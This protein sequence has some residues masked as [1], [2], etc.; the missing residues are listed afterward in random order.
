MP[1]EVVSERVEAQVREH[2]GRYLQA[3]GSSTGD[4][5]RMVWENIARTGK[6]PVAED[7]IDGCAKDTWREFME[8]REKL[9]PAGPRPASMMREQMRDM[10]AERYA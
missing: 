6:I 2:A 7:P 5:I 3:A 10:I 1:T 9:S 4:V 8:F